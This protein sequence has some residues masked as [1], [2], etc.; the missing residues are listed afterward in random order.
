MTARVVAPMTPAPCAYVARKPCGC[1]V[2]CVVKEDKYAKSTAE[3]I[4]SWVLKGWAVETVPVSDIQAGKVL[5]RCPHTE[6]A[7]LNRNARARAKIEELR[8]RREQVGPSMGNSFDLHPP[9]E[10]GRRRGKLPDLD[11]Y[12]GD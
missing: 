11:D 1:A 6:D 4:G 12:D 5:K 10:D 7:G 8:R 9:D 2:A 3:E